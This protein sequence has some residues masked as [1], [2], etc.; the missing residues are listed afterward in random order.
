MNLVCLKQSRNFGKNHNFLHKP[1][2]DPFSTWLCPDPKG[3][4]LPSY[5]ST[6]GLQSFPQ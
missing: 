6:S 3:L 1:K 2:T 4:G 5:L